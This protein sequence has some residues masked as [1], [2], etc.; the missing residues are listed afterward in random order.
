[1]I[2]PVEE[3]SERKEPLVER[4]HDFWVCISRGW[5]ELSK[6]SSANIS[7]TMSRDNL[8][9]ELQAGCSPALHLEC[10]SLEILHQTHRRR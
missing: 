10:W 1:M 8:T 4:K 6:S 2:E 5:R 9:L 7:L 3:V